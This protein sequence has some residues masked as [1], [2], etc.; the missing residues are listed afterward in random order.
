MTSCG[1]DSNDKED[2]DCVRKVCRRT[3]V[4]PRLYSN[5]IRMQNKTTPELCEIN[6]KLEK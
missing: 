5:S 4:G 2:K 3:Y 1:T 6:M